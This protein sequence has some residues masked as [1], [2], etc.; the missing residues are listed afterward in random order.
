MR[1]ALV[2][3]ALGVCTMAA[4]CTSSRNLGIAVTPSPAVSPDSAAVAAFALAAR[5]ARSFG[6]LREDRHSFTMGFKECYSD[7]RPG[8]TICGKTLDDEV[9]FYVHEMTGGEFSP[10]AK[11]LISQLTDSLS[12]LYGP[13]AVRE[14]KWEYPRERERIGCP[15]LV[16]RDST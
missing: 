15:V 3:L 12:A 8:M 16:R 11:N 7:R 14:C 6:L 1:T 13:G 4:T 9:Q 2:A 5:T 10:R